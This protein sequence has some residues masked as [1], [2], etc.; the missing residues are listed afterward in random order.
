MTLPPALQEKPVQI[1]VNGR[2]A[3]TIMTNT[4]DPTDLVVGQLYTERVVERY[5][6]IM[7]LHTDNRQTSV[8]TTK[9]FGILLS[10]K[11]V[12]AGCGGASSFL[13]SG[14][15]GKI[16]SD[17][18]LTETQIRKNFEEIPKTSWHSGALFAG[19]GTLL[20][21]VEDITSQNVLDCL[22]GRGLACGVVFADT[23]LLLAGNVVTESIRKAVIAQIPLLAFAGETTTA[24]I[25]AADDA[26][27]ALL[28][29]HGEEIR[30]L[31]RVC[32]ISPAEFFQKK[33]ESGLGAHNEYKNTPDAFI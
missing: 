30:Q 17:L 16:T 15:L 3:M 27:L 12:L 22:I 18:S 10:R 2:A 31:G 9:P 32:R 25:A 26:D 13:D 1:I 8:V 33:Q 20:A 28:R 6:D 19:D 21:A 11:T 29:I 7:S 5:A 24:A 4:D 14:K 23:Y